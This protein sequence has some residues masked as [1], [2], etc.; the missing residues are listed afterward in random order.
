MLFLF[1]Y[2]FV[3]ISSL[4]K[5]KKKKAFRNQLP[6]HSP[7]PKQAGK[8]STWVGHPRAPRL[9][10]THTFT[11]RP[12]PLS[13]HGLPGTAETECSILHLAKFN[14]PLEIQGQSDSIMHSLG[15]VAFG[16][17]R[18]F[19][20]NY[21]RFSGHCRALEIRAAGGPSTCYLRALKAVRVTR[22]GDGQGRRPPHP[23]TK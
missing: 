3:V 2:L 22:G 12:R 18:K 17:I 16:K 11:A 13:V 21:F 23:S 14:W 20:L 6:R 10:D 7:T 8:G 15:F 9:I 1:S 5:K 19:I 4:S